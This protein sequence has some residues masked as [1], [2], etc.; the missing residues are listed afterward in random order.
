MPEAD[1]FLVKGTPMYMGNRHEFYTDC[2]SAL[3]H[4]AA[5]IRRG[6]PQA[7][8]DFAAMSAD[9]LTTFLR[10]LHPQAVAAGRQL[11]HLL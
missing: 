5:S 8:H 1:Q 9:E 11:K 10:G 4:T 2:W 3:L 6:M 7:Q